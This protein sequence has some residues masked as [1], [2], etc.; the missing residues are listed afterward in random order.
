MKSI[1]D[2]LIVNDIPYKKNIGEQLKLPYIKNENIFLMTYI[3]KSKK[4]LNPFEIK[5]PFIETKD[6]TIQKENNNNNER[7]NSNNENNP[8]LLNNRKESENETQDDKKNLDN[9]TLDELSKYIAGDK[10]D[11]K[12]HRK[13]NKNR[14]KKK[15]EKIETNKVEEEKE[16]E[17][18]DP[19]VEEFIKYFIDYHRNNNECYTKIKPIISEEWI[20][21]IS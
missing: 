14:K 10:N 20:K 15:K 5:N 17:K 2:I 19:V 8:D 21:S 13:K 9:L 16:K 4:N 6:K 18:E 11:N 3:N 12:K 1:I 7:N